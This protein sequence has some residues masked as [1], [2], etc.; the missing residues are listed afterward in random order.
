VRVEVFVPQKA[1]LNITTDGSI[2]IDGVSGEV[3]LDGEDEA[4]NVRDVDG[5]L[6]VANGDGHIR[7]IGFRGEVDAETGDGL[8]NLEGDFQKLNARGGEGS[9]TLTLPENASADLEAN[10]PDIVGEGLDLKRV[11]TNEQKSRYRLGRGGPIYQIETAGAIVV[12]GSRSI[13]D[14]Q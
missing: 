14:G 11:S 12:R 2:R 5:K 8:I 7:V 4:I 13:T 10:C 6:T 9:I 1:N 3:K